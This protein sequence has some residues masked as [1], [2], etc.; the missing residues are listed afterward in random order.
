MA[1]W[2]DVLRNWLQTNHSDDIL[3]DVTFNY[4][5]GLLNNKRPRR[6]ATMRDVLR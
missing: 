5:V 1:A 3:N 6:E 2:E 4:I